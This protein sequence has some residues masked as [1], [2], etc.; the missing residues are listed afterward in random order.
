MDKNILIICEGKKTEP[1]IFREVQKAGFLPENINITSFESNIYALYDKMEKKSDGDWD[2]MDFLLTLSSPKMNVEDKKKLEQKYTDIL[3]IF[4]FD[5][6][7]PKFQEWNSKNVLI[8]RYTKLFKYFNEST[9]HGK[10]YLSYPMIESLL[11]VSCEELKSCNFQPFLQKKFNRKQLW[12][13]Q[14]KKDAAHEGENAFSNFISKKLVKDLIRFHFTKAMKIAECDN[15]DLQKCNIPDDLQKDLFNK[16]FQS[17]LISEEAYVVSTALF[18]TI[19]Y[20]P[21]N[22]M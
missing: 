7:D 12:S 10:L 6:Q 11:H 19:E 18:F 8:Q 16:E 20:N 13:K 3:L 4:D 2:S 22:I 9:D 1:Q 17:Y 21:K 15:E 14:Y 5:P